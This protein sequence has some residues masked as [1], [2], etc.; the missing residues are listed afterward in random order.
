MRRPGARSWVAVGL[1]AVAGAVWA[2]GAAA[3]PPSR[4]EHVRGDVASVSGDALTVKTKAGQTVALKLAPDL[5]VSR[6][7]KA[8][9]GSIGQGTFIGTTAVPQ[10]DGSLR[11]IEV[12]VFAE[13]M[14]GTGE[15]HRP[16]DLGGSSS[17]MTNATVA[18]VHKNAGQGGTGSTM[19]NATVAGV[20]KG[21][22]G[23]TLALEYQ[24]GKKTVLVPAGTPVVKMEPGDR[25]QLAPGAHVFAIAAREPD[26]TLVAKR[27]AVG[28]EI[29]PPM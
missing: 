6:V 19:T 16:W 27:I 28:K 14:R 29:A 23:E 20:K 25:A 21:G 4:D 2:Q 22:G 26:G 5:R 1:G 18:G 8:D 13:S 10:P 15:G 12:H 7:E 17:T 24:G 3:P 9:L 11:A